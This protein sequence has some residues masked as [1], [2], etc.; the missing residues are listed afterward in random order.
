ME[1]EP[2]TDKELNLAVSKLNPKQRDLYLDAL[3]QQ[4]EA[5]QSQNGDRNV[6]TDERWKIL[7]AIKDGSLV[8]NRQDVPSSQRSGGVRKRT[9]FT[10]F[11]ESSLP[12]GDRD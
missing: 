2:L 11:I 7:G 10:T 9:G 12:K 1:T 5:G 3:R 8:L 4:R 6:S